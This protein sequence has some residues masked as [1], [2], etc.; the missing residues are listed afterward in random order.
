MLEI[1]SKIVVDDA[2]PASVESPTLASALQLLP[3]LPS[4]QMHVPSFAT[5]PAPL[6]VAMSL[7]R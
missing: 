7:R 1:T 2:V 4:S 6:H 5:V 3:L